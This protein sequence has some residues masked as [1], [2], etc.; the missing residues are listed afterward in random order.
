MIAFADSYP[1]LTRGRIGNLTPVASFKVERNITMAG[2]EL[3]IL[4]T[5]W[6]RFPDPAPAGPGN[7]HELRPQRRAAALP[8]YPARP[9]LLPRAAPP[10]PAVVLGLFE[11]L[12]SGLRRRPAA[13]LPAGVATGLLDLRGAL[14]IAGVRPRPG[15]GCGGGSWRRRCGRRVSAPGPT[16][17][18]P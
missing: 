8:G 13:R 16:S 3:L 15:C 4:R 1:A 18:P 2:D 14:A 11:R 12:R 6:S 10:A 5:P 7:M 9:R 17:S